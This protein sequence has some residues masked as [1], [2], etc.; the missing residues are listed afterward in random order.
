MSNH[1]TRK[2]CTDAIVIGAGLHGL[3]AALHLARAGM[4]PVVLEKD[5]PGRHASGVNAG[6]VRRLGRALAEVPLS[7]AAMA[8]WHRIGDLVDDDCGFDACGQIKV[9]ENEEELAALD[10]RAGEL[11]ALGFD[12][13]ERVGRA[14]LR[15]LVPGIAPRCV[16]ALW[17]PGDGAASPFRTVMAFRRKAEALGARIEAQ[18]AAT[19]VRRG[20]NAWLVT[21]SRGEFEAPVLI[22]AAGAWGGNIARRLREPVPIRAE[23]PMLMITERVR[24]FLTPVLG[25]QGRTLSF[26]QTADNTLLI[27]GGHRGRAH[28][29]ENRTDIRV[30]GLRTSARTVAAL[31]P[32]LGDVRVVRVWAGI[33]GVMP[34]GVPVIGPSARAPDAYHAFGFSAHGFQLA[35]VVG[36]IIADLVCTGHTDMPIAAFRIDRFD[37]AGP[38]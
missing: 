36:R 26:K 15:A 7:V 29:A 14:E 10:R 6:G 34:D 12:H 16:G 33:E 19:G 23:A 17:C 37:T 13:E 38:T 22:N 25:A 20:A 4:K 2:T 5:Y 11:R 30:H 31:F 21:T 8:L 28:P 27:G 9:A 35:P 32:Q 3:S 18:A 24:A 1:S